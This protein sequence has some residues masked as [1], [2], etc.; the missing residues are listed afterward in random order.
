MMRHLL[1]GI[2]M[3]CPWIA[4]AAIFPV[5][6]DGGGG[7][8]TIQAA[9]DASAEGDTILLGDGVFSGP[10]NRELGIPRPRTLASSGGDPMLC[11][12]DPAG[13]SLGTLGEDPD[14]SHEFHFQGIAFRGGG[15]WEAYYDKKLYFDQCR[16][17]SCDGGAYVAGYILPSG[18][19]SLE[20]CA[21]VG[22]SSGGSG[23]TRPLFSTK[24]VR[25]SDCL[26][27]DNESDESAGSQLVSAQYA[28][29]AD[30]LFEGNQGGG[31]NLSLVSSSGGDTYFGELEARRCVFRD[32]AGGYCLRGFRE[33]VLIEG[34]RFEGNLTHGIDLYSEWDPYLAEVRDCLFAGSA[35]AGVVCYEMAVDLAGCS[36]ILGGGA[37][38]IVNWSGSSPRPMTLDR[39]LFAFRLAGPVIYEQNL[40]VDVQASC[41]D[42][43]GIAGGD[44]AGPLAGQLGI[45]GNISADPQFCDWPGG[46]YSLYEDSPCLPENN[47]CG[48]LM[49]ALGLGCTGPTAAPRVAPAA[50]LALAAHPNPFN[51][52][53]TIRFTLGEAGPVTLSVHDA[54]G[55]RVA[56][57]LDNALLPGGSQSLDWLADG[58]PSGV[59]LARLT[60]ARG[61]LSRKLILLR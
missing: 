2:L 60:A 51:P 57:L 5:E 18:L 11:V 19:I 46:D 15:G 37:G 8:A 44:W 16:F 40:A 53:T 55:R 24:S 13:L 1:I 10:G 34:C 56:T 47:D 23:W 30:C 50:G 12:I 49:G 38:D 41:T 43:F 33:N 28:T 9:V 45:D 7:Y 58:L 52:R 27:A 36:F 39:C 31:V 22:C 54:A 26:F 25:A 21:V 35:G 61:E 42:I 4:G 48:L 6:A 17:E 32:N 59:Y 3:I 20:H 29:L 14:P